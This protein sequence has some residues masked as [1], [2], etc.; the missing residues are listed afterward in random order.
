MFRARLNTFR[1]G[2]Q[3]LHPGKYTKHALSNA[4]RRT[5][6]REGFKY[7]NALNL[8]IAG[9]LFGGYYLQDCILLDS[10]KLGIP[11]SEVVKHNSL[12]TGIWV[13]LNNQVYDLTDFLSSHPGGAKIIMKYA[14]K[15]AS[16]IF[17]KFHAPDV[18][19]KFLSPEKCLGPLLGEMELAE[20]ITETEEDEERF[21][22]IEKMP[23]MSRVFNLSDFEYIASKILTKGAWAYYSGGADDEVSLR[24]NHYAFARIFFNPKVLID[25]KDV[26]IS[27]TM[28]GVKTS[29]PFYCSAAA[30]A[31]LGHP[32]GEIG[33]TKGCGAEGIIQMISSASSCSFDD[34]ADAAK[35]EQSQWFQLY[36][37]ENRNL[38]YDVIKHCEEKN[39]KGLF[40]TV[41]SAKFGN[42]EKD[43][44]LKLFDS[45]D[46]MEENGAKDTDQ[47]L[48]AKDVGLT[49][50]DI[51]DF[52]KLTKMPVV[53]KG[54]QR[55]E[56]V[57]LAIEH[58]A[59]AV[60]LS[61][62]GGRQ[63]DFSRSPVELLADV[64]PVLK[65]KQL[66][67]KIE[68]YIDGGIRRG[69]DVLKALCLGAKG[70]GLGRPFLYA[71]SAYG[72][73]GV[74]RAIQIL[75]TEIVTDMKLLGVSKIED[76]TPELLDLRNLYSRP[77]YSDLLYN[78]GYKPLLPV[79][80]RN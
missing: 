49:W 23:A 50:K 55:V 48:A 68:I 74:E 17:N 80:F 53:I 58:K 46:D 39:M 14:G 79:S 11:A 19:K 40:V 1:R 45:D 71:N 52:K 28:L 31:R 63:L 32:D 37:N 13:V 64:M 27:T 65:E 5:S 15:D 10:P 8:M 3:N 78:T 26:D 9:V 76:L 51:D 7:L 75:K 6:R 72:D 57:L 36:V 34:I 59:D 38:T 24:E 30:Q 29:A 67:K 66:D 4:S 47:I 33:I 73:K 42:R 41:D 61:N 16:L 20:D 56:D 22:Y 69:T 21:K 44:R 12:E 62:H 35:P 60:V 77:V 54:V 25:F 2:V 70:V 18:I 43:F